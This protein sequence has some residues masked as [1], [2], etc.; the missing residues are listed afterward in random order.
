MTV[1]AL[2][3]AKDRADSVGATVLALLSVPAVDQVLVIDDGSSDGTVDVALAAGAR[4]LRLPA[5]VG[6]GGAVRAGVE[7]TPHASVYLLI[8]ADV[9]ATASAGAEVLLPPVLD[10]AADMT[11]GVLPSAEGRGG[12]G[13]VRD[14]ARAGIRRACGFEARAPLSGQRAIGAP[15]LRSLDLAS[16]FGLETA[17]TIDVVRRGGS[18]VEVD[19]AMDHH[20]TGRSVRGFWHRGRQGADVVRALWPRLTT[21]AQRIGAMVL[22]ALLLAAVAL[23]ESTHVQPSSAAATAKPD[24]VVIFGIPKLGW[25]DVGNGSMPTLDGLV[26]SGAVA[27]TSVRTQ[28]S[29]PLTAEAYATVGAGTRVKADDSAAAA[30]DASEQAGTEPGTAAEALARRTGVAPKGDVAV[31]GAPATGLLNQ[32]KHLSSQPGA[33]GDAL[34]AA[35]KRTAVVGNADLGTSTDR[36]AAAALMDSKGEVDSGTVSSALLAPD[37]A[38]P[39]GVRADPA[40]VVRATQVALQ[41]ADVVVVDS[42]D[43]D[44]SAHFTTVATPAAARAERLRALRDTDALLGRVVALAGPRAL[45]LVVSVDPAGQTWRTTPMVATGAG[46]RQGY[47][48]SPSVRRV[49][50]VTITDVAPTVL[51]AVGVP[52]PTGM[53]GHPLRYHPGTVRLEQLRRLDRD[54]AF[55]ERI[56]FPITLV[57][58]IF[59]AI[60][61]LLAMVAFGRL[62]GVGG[63]ARLLR[64]IVL[65]VAAWPLA[66]FVFRALPNM[67]AL[68]P[69]AVAVLLAVNAL[70]VA[71]ALRARRHP[72]APLSW[73]LGVTV[74][75][76]GVDLATGARLQ[77]SS[78]L[79]Y[80]IHTA[81]RFTGIGNTAFAVLAASA[82]LVGVIHLQH[83][84]RRREALVAVAALF[85]LVILVDG[86]PS[87]GDDV[88]GILTLVPVLGISLLVLTGRRVRLRTL[89]IAAVVTLVVLGVATGVD[90]L[91]PPEA[92]TH[93]G[94]LV[95][96]VGSHGSGTFFTTVA[97]KLATNLRTY[98]SVWLW[99]IVIVAAYMLFFFGWARG[100]SALLPQRSAAR[101]GV[102]AVLAAGLLGNFLNDSGAVVTALVFVYMGPFITLLAL[103]RE[104]GSP[105]LLEPRARVGTAAQ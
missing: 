17:L 79:G 56:Y 61:Y 24:K 95:S 83:A 92:R 1:V 53:I 47:L 23:V 97:R 7:A 55:R 10:G 72:L 5:N 94:Q 26:R 31:V 87:L 42:G 21:A 8:D 73:I 13:K 67:A 90:L 76:I 78:I 57:Y 46:V 29:K 93:L 104:R 11:V 20:H 51:D 38:A 25:A 3:P 34:H 70:I 52:V 99:V 16:R 41:E 91:R 68:G 102:M 45:V 69:W 43:M 88:G 36:P 50:V 85:A 63:G 74:G 65:G 98:K 6:K 27:A 39:F 59:Q 100:W 96:S 62:G 54:A 32:G 77:V 81:A 89:A 49:G 14:L 15:L 86:A 82:I 58:I 40:A 19:V 22:V 37:A 84:P 2:V 12:L 105:V 101:V 33:L 18:V 9:G 30:Y 80:S 4:V 71:L 44:R 28:S 103:E 60:V 64:W 66:T 75:L 48:H 35:G